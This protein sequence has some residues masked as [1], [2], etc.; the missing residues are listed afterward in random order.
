MARTKYFVTFVDSFLR[1]VWIYMMKSKRKWFEG[2][3]EIQ[4]FIEMQSKHKI[5]IILVDVRRG[6]HFEGFE[7]FV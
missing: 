2:F 7:G 6:L 5:Q 1:K 4:I 3:K